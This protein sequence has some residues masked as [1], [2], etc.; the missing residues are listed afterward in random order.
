MKIAKADKSLAAELKDAL[1][2]LDFDRAPPARST[3]IHP[4]AGPEGTISG[5]QFPLNTWALTYDDG[6]HAKY[7]PMVFANLA[8]A[9][10]HASF[11]WLVQCLMENN[12][13]PDLAHAAGMSTNDHSWTHANLA[14]AATASLTKEITQS[15]QKD[16]Q[17]YGARPRFFRLP[18]GAG[19]NSKPARTLIAQNG[20]IHV[21]WNVDSL[22]WQD[23]EPTSILARVKKQ[24]LLEKKGIIL[25]H[26]I[27][28]QSVE[29]SKLVLDWSATLDGTHDAQRWVTIPEIVDELNSGH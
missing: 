20:M 6:P 3:Q 29:G 27:H 21:F 25:F 24:M 15:S 19:L 12:H 1:A 16:S 17:F 2:S 8:A 18:Y 22:D 28:P 10:K 7:T 26:D 13:M 9:H 5:D 23:K 14:K 4:S 11:M